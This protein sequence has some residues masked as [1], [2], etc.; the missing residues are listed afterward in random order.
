MSV[1][2]EK[3]CENI[4][5]VNASAKKFFNEIDEE[6]GRLSSGIFCNIFF[7]N[8]KVMIMK[9]ICLFEAKNG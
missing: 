7:N 3:K 4:L 5:A 6:S 8:R 2:E 9:K 1:N